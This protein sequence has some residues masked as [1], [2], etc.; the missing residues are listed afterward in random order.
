M[1]THLLHKFT[2][3]RNDRG[4]ITVWGFVL[5]LRSCFSLL[6]VARNNK[7]ELPRALLPEIIHTGDPAPRS[8]GGRR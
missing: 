3:T 6:K 5:I 4:T 2:T 7:L 1:N 8:I